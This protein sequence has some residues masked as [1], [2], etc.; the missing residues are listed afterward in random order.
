M[1][2]A[3]NERTSEITKLAREWPMLEALVGGTTAMR[4]AGVLLM[5]RFA[6]EDPGA[7]LT[8]ISVS[9]L[10]PAFQRT[11]SV[12]AA[13]PFA[14]GLTLSKDTPPDI[15]AWADD[16]DREGVNLHAFASEMLL[17]ALQ[18]GL[19]GVLVEAP[20][21]VDAGRPLTRAEQTDN[22]VRPYFVR[23]MHDQILGYRT[24]R[25][26]GRV[27]LTQLRLNEPALEPDGDYGEK[28]VERVRVLRPGAWEVWENI[29]IKDGKEWVMIDE[30]LSGLPVI[31]FVPFYGARRG[32]MRG[33]SPLLNLAHNNVKHW[34]SQ[35]DQDNILHVARVPILFAAGF[36]EDT[37]IAIGA[38]TAIRST[39]AAA[40]IKW[41]EH[42]G[43]AIG[44]GRE[45]LA[46][47]QEQMIQ[48]GAELL[49]K[50]PGARTATES[51][52]DAEANKSDLQRIAETFEDSLDQALQYMA[53]YAGLPTG[54]EVSLHKDFGAATL[55]DAS[56]QLVLAMQQ[57]G[58]ISDE[59]AIRE[60]QRRGML[61]DDL[62][63]AD[64]AERVAMQDPE[65]TTNDLQAALTPSPDQL[66][67]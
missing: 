23:V 57:G 58:L 15:E 37:S 12:M 56:A 2:L 5:P 45:S 1:P 7:H 20:R 46:D 41:V 50:R 9:T 31:P 13:K 52:S 49:V 14:K 18:F 67:A 19:C 34:Q 30:G 27:R 26:D 51:A 44:A 8:R 42:S 55:T 63:P 11:A 29:G 25:K 61:S 65:P 24:E 54:G 28:T 17:E 53:D 4:D 33:V 39:D 66:A 21:L 60:M 43:A 64:E 48:A 16:I 22:G 32:F 35:S 59:T 38:S 36:P 47:L 40:D 62:D 6:T 3:V 10:F